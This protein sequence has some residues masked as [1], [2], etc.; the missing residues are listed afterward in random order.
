MSTVEMHLAARDLSAAMAE[1]RIWLDQRR[2][3]PAGFQCREADDGVVVRVDFS[4]ATEAEAFA[5]RFRGRVDAPLAIEQP[6]SRP[7]KSPKER[8]ALTV[9]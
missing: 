3:E 4:I 5:G 9:R 6:I 2:F 7:L 1:M 8:V